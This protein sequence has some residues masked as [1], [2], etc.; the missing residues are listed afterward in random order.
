M[1]HVKFAAIH[2]NFTNTILYGIVGKF[3]GDNVWQKWA[4]EDCVEKVWQM[5]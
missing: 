5:S 4:D 1:C 3:G 2:W